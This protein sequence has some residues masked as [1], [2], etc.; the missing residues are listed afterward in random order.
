MR[1]NRNDGKLNRNM[2]IDGNH[3]ITVYPVWSE[4]LI[5]WWRSSETEEPS[6]GQKGPLFFTKNL[7][8]IKIGRTF[9][10]HILSENF[11][12]RGTIWWDRVIWEYITCNWFNIKVKIK[13][14][15]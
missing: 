9:V 14:F 6:I 10:S 11:K 15:F 8:N 1:D 2:K 4:N 12:V 3:T 5:I 13:V 7:E